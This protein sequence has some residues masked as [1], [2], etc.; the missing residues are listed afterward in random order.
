MY[1]YLILAVTAF[2][3]ATLLPLGSEVL[4]LYY[5]TIEG[6]LWWCLWLVASSFNT[7]GAVF[8]WW[9]G[10]YLRRYENHKYFPISPAQIGYA[11]KQF[12]Q[13]GQWS[14][15]FTWLPVIGD[16]FSLVAGT[17]RTPLWV[18][19]PLAFVGKAARYGFLLWGS[20]LLN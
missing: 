9:L 18:L 13:Y 12:R 16:A 17:F 6:R 10:G 4:L 3:A 5:A 20:Y 15:L 1:D 11:E 8:N 19:V 14:L 2:L 7:L